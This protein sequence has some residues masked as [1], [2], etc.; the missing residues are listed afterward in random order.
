MKKDIAVLFVSGK[1]I[2]IDLLDEN[3]ILGYDRQNEN[4]LFYISDLHNNKPV[5]SESDIETF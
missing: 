3:K 5:D 4:G 2:F 1:A